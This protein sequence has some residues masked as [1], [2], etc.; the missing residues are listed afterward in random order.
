MSIRN[1]KL[2]YT[3]T[4]KLLNLVAIPETKQAV[5][6]AVNVVYK[7]IVDIFTGNC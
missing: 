6:G 5:D 2:G 4:K 3:A 7:F 1:F